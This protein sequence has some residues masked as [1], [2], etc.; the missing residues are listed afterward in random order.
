MGVVDPERA[1]GAYYIYM[2]ACVELQCMHSH[3]ML[4]LIVACRMHI[5]VCLDVCAHVSTSLVTCLWM[6]EFMVY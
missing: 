1:R 2:Y 5:H 3:I 4:K 6:C